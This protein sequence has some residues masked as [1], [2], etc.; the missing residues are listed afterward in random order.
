MNMKRRWRADLDWDESNFDWT[1]KAR[2]CEEMC[3]EIVEHMDPLSLFLF[4]FVS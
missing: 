1:D 2:C 4:R 3:T